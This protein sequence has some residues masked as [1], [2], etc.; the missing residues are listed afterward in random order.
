MIGSVMQAQASQG[1]RN[2]SSHSRHFDADT[3]AGSPAG[4]SG[5]R[6]PIQSR[7]KQKKVGCRR[8]ETR[9]G[10]P[11]RTMVPAF[12]QNNPE[13]NNATSKL[14][15]CSMDE[16]SLWILVHNTVSSKARANSRSFYGKWRVVCSVRDKHFT[17]Y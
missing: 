8:K 6:C 3:A 17:N 9:V 14:R 1:L 2:D 15:H 16:P 13:N 10:V 12:L 5:V 7:N 4:R 11:V